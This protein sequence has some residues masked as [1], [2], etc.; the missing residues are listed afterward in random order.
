MDR[1]NADLTTVGTTLNATVTPALLQFANGL[2][3]AGEGLG[4]DLKQL[5]QLLAQHAPQTKSD[6]Y[7]IPIAGGIAKAEDTYFYGGLGAAKGWLGGVLGGIGGN[8]PTLP[9]QAQMVQQLAQQQLAGEAR[10]RW[11]NADMAH[12][13]RDSIG[14]PLSPIE[15]ILAA[16]GASP[17]YHGITSAPSATAPSTL[18]ARQAAALAGGMTTSKPTDVV[19]L[20]NELTYLLATGGSAS[21]VSGVE[22]QIISAISTSSLGPGTKALDSYQLQQEVAGAAWEPT[23]LPQ[24]PSC[25]ETTALA[26]ATHVQATGRQ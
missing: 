8:S 25:S 11:Y 24:D 22:Q 1:F 5:H 23:G 16:Q 6:E 14:A 15:Q 3:G 19:D 12:S 26:M 10:Q 18:A 17:A 7:S 13:T 20:Q 4:S 21:K 9:T 2:L